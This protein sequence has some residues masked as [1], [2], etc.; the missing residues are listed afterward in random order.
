[1]TGINGAL[2]A[3][4]PQGGRLAARLK[5]AE[6]WRDCPVYLPDKYCRAG[7]DGV[8]GYASLSQLVRQLFGR[9]DCLVFFCACGIAVRMVGPLLTGKY[10]DPAVVVCDEGGNFA[11]S[12]L[13]GHAGGANALAAEIG[14]LL[15]ATPVIT[16]A[17]DVHGVFAVDSWA[18]G[19]QL[20][21]AEKRLVKDISARLL[22]G[23]PVGFCSDYR[24]QGALPDGLALQGAQQWG[25]CVSAKARQPFGHTLHLHPR[26]L[27][28]GVGCRKGVTAEQLERALRQLLAQYGLAEP[29]IAAVA[30]IDLK[31]QEPGLLAWT[32]S[33]SLPITFYTAEQLRAVT[34]EFSRSDF[35]RQITGVDNVCERSAA[36]AS[37]GRCVA[38]KQ[39]LDGVTMAV[40]ETPL[41]LVF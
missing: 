11:I 7:Q 4:S 26:N 22:Q 39:K 16:T 20:Y 24:W 33:K 2:L 28:L 19:Q 25:I 12:L 8:H 14:S 40:Y 21:I 41:T 13:S 6:G 34:G 5:R 32:A 35:V 17:T 30:T 23:K 31:R 18:G 38:A 29:C 1:M 10:S 15:G 27:I 3:C 9:C 36:L 37:G